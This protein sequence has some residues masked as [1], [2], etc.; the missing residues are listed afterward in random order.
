MRSERWGGGWQGVYFNDEPDHYNYIYLGKSL[1]IKT[2][3]LSRR[4]RVEEH[5]VDYKGDL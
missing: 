4:R 1:K 5:Q 2:T 3:F